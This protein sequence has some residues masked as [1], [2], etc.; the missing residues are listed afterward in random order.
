MDNGDG[1]RVRGEIELARN[2]KKQVVAEDNFGSRRSDGFT[3]GTDP[4][5]PHVCLY[6]IGP[7]TEAD[8]ASIIGG[9][10]W[11]LRSSCCLNACSVRA[12]VAACFSS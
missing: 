7:E 2:L 10:C 8:E 9:M 5:I 12:R 1:V 11:C 6:N 4:E 3:K